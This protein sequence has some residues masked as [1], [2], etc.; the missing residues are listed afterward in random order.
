M[1]CVIM[2]GENGKDLHKHTHTQKRKPQ[3]GNKT[4]RE[5]WHAKKRRKAGKNNINSNTERG[6]TGQKHCDIK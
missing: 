5:Q 3:T 2:W 6:K 4:D 1:Y